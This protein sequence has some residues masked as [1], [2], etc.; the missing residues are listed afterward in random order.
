MGLKSAASYFQRMMMASVVQAGLLYSIVE[1]YLDDVLVY[2]TS[3]DELIERLSTV[4]TRLRQFNITLNPKKCSFGM[5]AEASQVFPW[6][7]QL[8]QR[9]C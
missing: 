1:L 7:G 2:A 8:F 4:F 6:A 5:E 9:P 3:E